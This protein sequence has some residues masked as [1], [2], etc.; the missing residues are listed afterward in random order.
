MTTQLQLADQWQYEVAAMLSQVGSIAVPPEILS[1]LHVGLPLTE[2]ERRIYASRG[3]VGYDLLARIPRLE[4]V[5]RMVRGQSADSS[6]QTGEGS[7]EAS[8]LGSRML[9]VAAA[10]DDLIMHG[11]PFA[12]AATKMGHSQSYD[13]ALV[14]ALET[15]VEGESRTEICSLRIADLQ[16]GMVLNADVRTRAGL[17][18]LGKGQEITPSVIAR[19]RGFVGANGVVEPLSVACRR[20]M[21]LE[22]ED[23]GQLV[24]AARGKG[25]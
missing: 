22:E 15:M 5:A 18:L 12:A 14:A 13:P 4:A 20:P 23:T 21:P 7:G 8:A 3:Q 10:F 6:A 1:K 17:L 11:T 9:R 25:E 24:P 19:L 2:G 16:P